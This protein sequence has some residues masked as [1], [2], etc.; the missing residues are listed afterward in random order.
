MTGNA[1][2]DNCFVLHNMN[3]STTTLLAAMTDVPIQPEIVDNDPKYANFILI[4]IY[5]FG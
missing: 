1:V 3:S 5:F 2:S 4:S